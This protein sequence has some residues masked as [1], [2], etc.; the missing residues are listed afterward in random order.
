MSPDRPFDLRVTGVCRLGPT[1]VR[2]TAAGEDLADFAGHG[3]DQRINLLFGAHR[4]FAATTD[5]VATWQAER[6]PLRTYTVRAFRRQARE[7]DVDFVLHSDAGPASRWAGAVRIGDPLTMIGPVTGA[8]VADVAWAP[9]PG[10]GRLLLAADEAAV[11]AAAAIV[12]GL[13]GRAATVV[14]EV[15]DP[16]DA[17]V[18]PATPGVELIWLCRARGERLGPVVRS[19]VADLEPPAAGAD[20]APES[21]PDDIWDVPDN[22]EGG[23]YAWLAGE[24]GAVTDL[25]RHLVRDRGFDRRSV[26]FMGY[27]KRGRAQAN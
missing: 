12:E 14:L 24:A 6:V 2:V 10:A 5:W 19:L 9:P 15:P 18:V 25:R 1:F 7:V 3:G 17:T 8:A 21:D 27:W 22:A 20:A 13:G 26:A 4:A 11:P 16:A 23:F